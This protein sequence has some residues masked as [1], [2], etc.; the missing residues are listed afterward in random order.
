M[1]RSHPTTIGQS[2]PRADAFEKVTGKATYVDDLQF[3][4]MIH[5]RLVCC[6]HA[7]A[8]IKAIDAAEAL[9]LPGVL[10]FITAADMPAPIRPNPTV[11]SR[12]VFYEGQIVAAV[13]AL[14]YATA[15]DA[16]ALVRVDYEP[17]P[18]VADLLEAS[19]PAAPVIHEDREIQKDSH[20]HDLPPNVGNFRR[21][22]KGNIRKG[23][24]ESDYVFEDTFRTRIQHHAPLETHGA[25]AQFDASAGAYT[26]WTT[27]AGHH[28][29][30]EDLARLFGISVNQVRVVA[31][32]QGGGFGG[33]NRY[34]VEPICMVLAR[35]LG[36]PVKLILTREEEMRITRGRSETIVE[37]KTGVSKDGILLARK[38]RLSNSGGAYGSGGGNYAMITGPYR[39]QH[40]EVECFGV[41]TDTPPPTAFR[42]PGTPEIHFAVESHM[43]AIAKAL[44]ID[45]YELRA[46][47]LVQEGD[48]VFW[49]RTMPKTGWRKTLDAAAQRSGWKNRKKKRNHG[50]GLACGKWPCHAG[51]SSALVILNSDGSANVMTGAVD[52]TGSHTALRQIA[53]ETLG[54]D[55]KSV[56]LTFGDSLSSPV[57]DISAGSRITYGVG[58]AVKKAAEDARAQL[59]EGAA[60]A[61]QL[62][63][64]SLEIADGAIRSKRQPKKA[65]AISELVRLMNHETGP[66][67]GRGAIADL[68][69]APGLAVQVAEVKV[70]P[71]T[72][73]VDVLRLTCAQD[74]G[75]AINPAAV[76]GQIEGAVLQGF[77]YG[78]T[79]EYV[80]GR[81]PDCR[82]LNPSFLDY[83]LP[84]SLDAPQIRCVLVEEPTEH[85][86]FGARGI[87]EPSVIPTAPAI[88]NAIEDATGVRVKELPITPERLLKALKQHRKARQPED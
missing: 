77:G 49:S 6:P 52:V 61:L 63:P 40:V 62:K 73:I 75:V 71:E 7:R 46:R 3:P 86:A 39:I 79:E 45:P 32:T 55:F 68:P 53:A 15:Q 26:I 28:C 21:Y 80:Y 31:M 70:D 76:E 72:G 65:I 57:N 12:D 13:A 5:A 34:L 59:L 84:T 11:A 50:W 48:F 27:T 1:K 35:K 22:V 29:A 16:A 10:G 18:A 44:Q 19:Q 78:L 88:A 25:I 17:L 60:R 81:Q 14:D 56:T 58:A 37:I 8:S 36:R 30:A 4:S 82:L 43:D 69:M 33:K 20:G 51:R 85:G 38:A 74:V 41:D 83:R 23:F 24:A 66:I 2:L 87:G 42:A 9:K 64:A 54:L 47:N 67:M